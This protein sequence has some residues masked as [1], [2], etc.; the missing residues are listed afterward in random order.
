MVLRRVITGP[1]RLLTTGVA[2]HWRYYRTCLAPE[3]H[4]L[5][6][7]LDELALRWAGPGERDAQQQCLAGRYSSR[8][9]RLQ[10]QCEADP[11]F[12]VD[13]LGYSDSSH[14]FD[15]IH[16]PARDGPVHLGG[17]RDHE[18]L[19]HAP[20]VPTERGS[21]VRQNIQGSSE[22]CSFVPA[23]ETSAP[24][25]LD[26]SALHAANYTQ[27][28]RFPPTEQDDLSAISRILMD[29]QF[30]DMDRVISFDDMLFTAQTVDDP[31][32]PWAQSH[33]T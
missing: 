8:L 6:R 27:S 15:D 20:H 32:M 5:V 28:L 31:L 3:F 18:Q 7:G 24:E 19:T 17:S 9:K 2:V 23:S 13:V 16:E 25:Q 1:C 14:H 26:A 29:Q 21:L 33:V 11:N 30:L 12:A 22:T 4:R 10:A